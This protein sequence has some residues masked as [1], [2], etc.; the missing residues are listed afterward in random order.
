MVSLYSTPSP[1]TQHG[2]VTVSHSTLADENKNLIN[3]M[4][5][6]AS[7]DMVVI[8]EIYEV[9]VCNRLD[10][11]RGKLAKHVSMAQQP[12]VLII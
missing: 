7:D 5:R 12:P 6:E 9:Q 8:P 3:V 10:S 1:I 2:V 4:N 11:S